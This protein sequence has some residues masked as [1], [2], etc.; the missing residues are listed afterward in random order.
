MESDRP[1]A[2]S[3]ASIVSPSGI[4]NVRPSLESDAVLMSVTVPSAAL[5]VTYVVKAW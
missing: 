3:K 5:S 4:R 2:T 1:T